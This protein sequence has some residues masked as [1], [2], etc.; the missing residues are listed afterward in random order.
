MEN[1]SI[2]CHPTDMVRDQYGQSTLLE[3]SI[4]DPTFSINDYIFERNL[5]INRYSSPLAAIMERITIYEL[6]EDENNEVSG[7]LAGS[8]HQIN[9]S[10]DMLD[11]N[12]DIRFV[13]SVTNMQRLQNYPELIG[14]YVA[15]LRSLF[16]NCHDKYSSDA[17]YRLY[18]WHILAKAEANHQICDL[19][20]S[21]LTVL[22]GED[23]EF[24]RILQTY[25]YVAVMLRQSLD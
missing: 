17:F 4:I 25:L 21:H 14:L 24:D 6:Y 15:R 22:A 1:Y 8:C 13:T 11:R 3:D 20:Y 12:S 5:R 18:F 7:T 2:H 19:Y 10:F 23:P 16:Y 9:A